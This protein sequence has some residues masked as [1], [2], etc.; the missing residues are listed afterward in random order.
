MTGKCKL[1]NR[2]NKFRLTNG[3]KEAFW[4]VL[5]TDDFCLQAFCFHT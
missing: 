4:V 5:G 2:T 3:W 1:E